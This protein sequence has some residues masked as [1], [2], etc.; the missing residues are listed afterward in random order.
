MVSKERERLKLPG[1]PMSEM[2]PFFP[3]RLQLRLL[4]G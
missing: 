3:L 2:S 4:V 1:G